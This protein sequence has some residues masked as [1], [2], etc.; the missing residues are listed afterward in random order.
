MQERKAA[1]VAAKQ[2]SAERF[3]Q[4]KVG[5]NQP[6]AAATLAD[7]YRQPQHAQHIAA[8]VT[9]ASLRP[10]SRPALPPPAAQQKRKRQDAPSI[11]AVSATNAK[12]EAFLG[13]LV[14]H[15]FISYSFTK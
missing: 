4:S 3:K 7:L 15:S 10:S 11:K 1:A 6:G 5:H 8:D 9:A 12:F 2:R 14:V 13:D